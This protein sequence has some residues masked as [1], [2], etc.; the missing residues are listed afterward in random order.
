M[1]NA[2]FWDV[3]PC[4]SCVNRRFGGIYRLHLQSRKIRERGTRRS[5][6]LYSKSSLTVSSPEAPSEVCSKRLWE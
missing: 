3:A 4:R 5:I 6:E 2:V 1:K